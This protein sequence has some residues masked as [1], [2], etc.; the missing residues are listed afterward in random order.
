MTIILLLTLTA[1]LILL[2]HSHQLRLR[3]E[4]LETAHDHMDHD[5]ADVEAHIH[6]TEVEASRRRH[7]AYQAAADLRTARTSLEARHA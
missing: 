4:A 6:A 1:I 7:P 5:L 3:L 2:G